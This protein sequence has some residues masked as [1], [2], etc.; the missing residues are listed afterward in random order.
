MTFAHSLRSNCSLRCVDF[1]QSLLISHQVRALVHKAVVESES[2]ARLCW[3]QEEWLVHVSNMLVVNSSL[4]ELHLGMAGIT[5]T[6]VERLAEGL[7]RNH[8]LRYLDLRWYEHR[9]P[10]NPQ[11]PQEMM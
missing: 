10:P 7:L 2:E 3:C 5:D 9:Q 6:G 11:T 8:S 1:S 4:L